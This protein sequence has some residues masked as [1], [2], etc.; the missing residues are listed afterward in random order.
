MP[1][2]TGHLRGSSPTKDAAPVL[3]VIA[4]V[5]ML[6]FD[7]RLSLRA[8]GPQLAVNRPLGRPVCI[9]GNLLANLPTPFLR[10]DTTIARGVTEDG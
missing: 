10:A 7:G 8:S 4:A 6:S 3:P 2:T 1:V 9:V 5:W